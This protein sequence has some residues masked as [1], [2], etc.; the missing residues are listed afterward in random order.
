PRPDF[1]RYE[2]CLN[3]PRAVG[4]HALACS[5][6]SGGGWGQDMLKRGHQT[7]R[8]DGANLNLSIEIKM[9]IDVVVTRQRSALKANYMTLTHPPRLV[10]KCYFLCALSAAL[11]LTGQGILR[12]GAA[13]TA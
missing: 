9:I 5:G 2:C 3:F 1:R 13:A 12:A 6:D 8:C 4:A 11:C 7:Q 10:I